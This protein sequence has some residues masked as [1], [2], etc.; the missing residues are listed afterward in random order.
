VSWFHNTLLRERLI[1]CA[2]FCFFLVG[3]QGTSING[4]ITK[5]LGPSG[6]ALGFLL[7]GSADPVPPSKQFEYLQVE[8]NSAKFLMALGRRTIDAN[9]V[10]VEHWYSGQSELLE[11]RNGRIWRL[12]GATT[13]WR[14]QVAA[15]PNWSTLANAG[16]VKWQRQLDIMPDYRYGQTDHIVSHRL[17]TPPATAPKTLSTQPQQLSW[18]SDTITSRDEAGQPWT[19]EQ[20]F[21]ID[22]GSGHPNG[23]WIY[24]EQCVSPVMCVKLR[25]LG[26]VK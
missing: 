17:S 25:Y 16:Q 18:F 4:A 24:S 11:I 1:F 3:C 5:S 22:S 19:F 15:P 9:N 26:F 12:S 8:L 7:R 23:R 13:E 20:V 10:V 2:F 21:A 6:E 14:G